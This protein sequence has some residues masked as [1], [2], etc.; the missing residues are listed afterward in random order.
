MITKIID[1]RQVKNEL[2]KDDELSV[3]VL[4]LL[5]NTGYGDTNIRNLNE[6]AI[7]LAYK[8][9]KTNITV[10]NEVV[11][12]FTPLYKTSINRRNLDLKFIELCNKY[13]A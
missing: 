1:Y 5:K 11:I 12:P 6:D 3:H 4:K 9:A 10:M 8:F 2:A 7:K 13:I